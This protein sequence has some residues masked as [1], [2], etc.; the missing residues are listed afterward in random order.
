[1]VSK[2]LSTFSHGTRK[3]HTTALFDAQANRGR[4][5]EE[6]G[7]EREGERALNSTA[8]DF[9][10]TDLGTIREIQ[11]LLEYLD[12]KKLFDHSLSLE[13]SKLPALLS[14]VTPETDLLS[15]Q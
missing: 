10:L 3:R 7:R 13:K 11:S 1:M 15:R 9:K 12:L 8:A 2:H 5:G 6:G 14:V 4:A